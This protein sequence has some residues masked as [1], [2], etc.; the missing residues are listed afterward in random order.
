MGECFASFEPT[1]RHHG[2]PALDE[3][4][5]VIGFALL[6]STGNDAIISQIRDEAAA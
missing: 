2:T 3:E 4:V 5:T 6:L 1:R